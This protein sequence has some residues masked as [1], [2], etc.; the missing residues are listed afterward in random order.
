MKKISLILVLG[1]IVLHVTS[2]PASATS[3]P[4][5]T[6]RDIEILRSRAEQGDTVSQYYLGYAYAN[7]KIVAKDEREA[8]RWYRQAAQQGHAEAARRLQEIESS[9]RTS[10]GKPADNVS[11]AN[12]FPAMKPQSAANIFEKVWQSVVVVYNG[13]GHGSGVVIQPNVVATNCHVVNQGSSIVVHKSVN[14]RADRNSVF[15]AAMRHVDQERDIC[16]LNVNGLQGI[17]ATVRRYN[18]IRVGERVYALGAPYGYN[19]SI[20]EG[21][22]SQLRTDSNNSWI[23]T[24]AAIS[25]GSSGGGLFDGDGNLIGIMTVKISDE[26]VE[27]IGFAI[28]AD[29]VLRQ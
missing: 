6:S 21:I 7:G 19:L 23:Q 27:G 24:D 17:P 10:A 13:N 1:F 4:I 18:T 12:A 28:P 11:V 9:Q 25:P 26:S 16:L 20:S 2:T 22:V 5:Y 15:H 8:V 29:L 3:E 14:R